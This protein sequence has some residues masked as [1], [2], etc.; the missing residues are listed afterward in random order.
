MNIKQNVL[1]TNNLNQLE[2]LRFYNI[3]H[4]YLSLN[5][6]IKILNAYARIKRSKNELEKSF[7]KL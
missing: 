5:K 2:H 4:Q 3:A 7:K 6:Q 1:I